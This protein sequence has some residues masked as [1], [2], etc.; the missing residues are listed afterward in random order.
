MSQAARV[1]TLLS[2][3]IVSVSTRLSVAAVLGLA[4]LPSPTA[5]RDLQDGRG[6]ARGGRSP[7]RGG[8]RQAG[9]ARRGRTAAGP[10]FQ[11]AARRSRPSRAQPEAKAPEPPPA[12]KTS[13]ISP[14]LL[15]PEAEKDKKSA[16]AA[17][18]EPEKPPTRR[19][20]PS[21]G[22]AGRAAEAPGL[23]RGRDHRRLAGVRET[24]G[25][26]RRRGRDSQP[27][28]HEVCGAPAPVLLKRSARG[29]PRWRSVRRPC[30]TAPWSRAC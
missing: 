23:V 3:A 7:D 17:T 8:P 19:R 14:A 20:T 28:R 9:S 27:V 26:D 12:H 25:A 1:L 24:A 11:L 4:A 5:G 16:S 10:A 18:P 13:A 22:G 2:K 29:P 21:P 6:D 15:Q 30:S